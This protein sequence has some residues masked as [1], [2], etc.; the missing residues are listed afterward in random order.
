[1]R[2]PSDCLIKSLLTVFCFSLFFFLS[3]Y[4][5]CHTQILT[6]AEA[7]GFCSSTGLCAAGWRG[8]GVTAEEGGGAGQQWPAFGSCSFKL[9]QRKH[10]VAWTSIS[11]VTVFLPVAMVTLKNYHCLKEEE[12]GG[13]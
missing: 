5:K 3:S 10:K 11:S 13:G 1:M 7:V 6:T 12:L 2:K 8:V 9:T 4:L